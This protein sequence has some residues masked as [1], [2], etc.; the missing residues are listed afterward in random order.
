MNRCCALAVDLVATNFGAYIDGALRSVSAL[1]SKEQVDIVQELFAIKM[2]KE[3]QEWN[4]RHQLELDAVAAKNFA[5]EKEKARAVF[6]KECELWE[7]ERK[8][9]FSS[10]K[11]GL[12][13]L[14][15]DSKTFTPNR[16]ERVLKGRQVPVY[17]VVQWGMDTNVVPDPRVLKQI[18]AILDVQAALN[19]VKKALEAYKIE[20]LDSSLQDFHTLVDTHNIIAER[21]AL[22]PHSRLVVKPLYYLEEPD[23]SGETKVFMAEVA[24]LAAHVA[25]FVRLYPQEL[26][27]LDALLQRFRF[28]A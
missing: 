2:Q 3:E 13:F 24:S 25:T 19:S 28:N 22:H 7:K 23:V 16:W 4:R 6:A 15:E 14:K 20:P 8:E 27:D 9:R 12:L 1:Y 11:V 21:A 18:K 26:K 10:A 5:T 17:S